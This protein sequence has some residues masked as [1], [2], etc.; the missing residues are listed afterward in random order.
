MIRLCDICQQ[1]NRKINITALELHP[2]PV[3]SPWY[4]IGNDLIG[5]I[6]PKSQQRNC[7]ILTISDYF[8]KFVDAIALPDK[9]APSVAS[10]LFKVNDT[11]LYEYLNSAE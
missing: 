8:T 1:T 11:K 6:S 3:V 2:V 7:Y 10:A 9:E 5:P 4:H